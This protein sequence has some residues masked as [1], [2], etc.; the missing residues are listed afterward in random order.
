ML[1]DKLG[2]LIHTA[3]SATVPCHNLKKEWAMK[4]RIKIFASNA[5]T[6]L[7]REVC[8]FLSVTLGDARVARFKDGEVDIQIREDVRGADVFIIG[9]THPP[10]E[11]LI[12][13][14]FLAETAHDS[15]AGSVTLAIP[16]L[17]GNRQDRKDNKLRTPISAHVVS[18]FL[19]RR[20]PDR[21]LLFDIH[22]EPTAAFFKP[23]LVDRLSAAKTSVPY[24]ERVLTEPF[25]V[26]APDVG[27]GKRA[28]DYAHFLGQHDPIFF[29]KTRAGAGEIKGV[30]VIGDV[31]GK[32][33]LFVDDMIDTGGTIIADAE[34]AKKAGAKDI[35]V[36][37]THALFSGEAVVK[38]DE[39]P[40]TEVIVTN[41]I[42]HDPKKLATKR[43]K[44]TVLSIAPLL[45]EAIHRIH[46]DES[47]SALFL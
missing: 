13:I 8:T 22:S 27:G 10:A 4:N 41:T 7:A 9:S 46:N 1:V 40:V 25:V 14:A 15:S 17:G 16:Y 33:V 39:S 18:D 30:T 29:S 20:N 43:V 37:A 21:F 6:V 45:A 11:N 35:F 26:A 3:H 32:N 23:L 47:L 44:I 31:S 5:S 24:L 12:E 42:H 2:L 34:A 28:R 19:V 38:L 36:F